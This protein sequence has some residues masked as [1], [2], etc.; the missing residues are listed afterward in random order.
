MKLAPGTGRKPV[1]PIVL[2]FNRPPRRRLACPVPDDLPIY[3]LNLNNIAKIKKIAQKIIN[4]TSL[5]KK[6]LLRNASKCSK[7]YWQIPITVA[8]KININKN[9]INENF[10]YFFVVH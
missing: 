8:A 4:P 7:K 6:S 5:Y 3:Y 2:V 9:F 10:I 1:F